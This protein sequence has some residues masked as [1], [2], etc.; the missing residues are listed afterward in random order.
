MLY[1]ARLKTALAARTGN[2]RNGSYS[3][4]PFVIEFDETS[5]K[6]GAVTTHSCI[7]ELS[8]KTFKT[9][10]LKKLVGSSETVQVSIYLETKEYNGRT[11]NEV[12]VYPVES[13]W[14]Q[15]KED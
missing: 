2:G 15:P 4:S 5:P 3:F 8:D 14:R 10:D 9:E 1:Q 6:T 12:N 13:K 7:M 11:F